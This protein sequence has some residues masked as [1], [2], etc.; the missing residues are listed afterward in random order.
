MTVE[1]GAADQRV[2]PAVDAALNLKTGG[3][4]LIAGAV[5][6]AIWWLLH[7]DTPAA[8]AEAALN[9]VRDRPIYPT[10]H[11][12]AVLVALVVVIGLLALTRSFDT[13]TG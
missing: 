8:D 7:G 13:R 4:C 2:G 9:F 12:F 3:I 10:V 11:I 5:V 1:A 6:F